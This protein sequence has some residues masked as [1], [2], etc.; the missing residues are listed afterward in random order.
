MHDDRINLNGILIFLGSLVVMVL[1][2]YGVVSSMTRKLENRASRA[3][4][5]TVRE[6]PPTSPSQPYFPSPREQPDPLIDLTSLRAREDAELNSY[7]WINKTSGVVRIPI[8][9]AIDILAAREAKGNP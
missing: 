7:G 6:I 4:Q 8:E 5:Q 2:S 1:I 3:D 9:R